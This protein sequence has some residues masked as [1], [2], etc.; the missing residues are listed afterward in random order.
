MNFYFCAMWKKKTQNEVTWNAIPQVLC[1]V[2]IAF[3]CEQ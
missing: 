3:N 1:I 2:E